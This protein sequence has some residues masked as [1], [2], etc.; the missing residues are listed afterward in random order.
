MNRENKIRIS[1][2]IYKDVMNNIKLLAVV[3]P[4]SIYQEVTS[5]EGGI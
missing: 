3:T 2:F 4:R 1:H 5:L